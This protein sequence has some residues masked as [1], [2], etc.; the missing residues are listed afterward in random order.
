MKK[1]FL[2]KLGTFAVFVFAGVLLSGCAGRYFSPS[3]CREPDISLEELE[4]KKQLAMDP[5]R[6]FADATSFVQRATLT[7]SLPLLGDT[8]FVIETF[9]KKPDKFRTDMRQD[10]KLIFSTIYNNGQAVRINYT[11]NTVTQVTG[12]ELEELN[13][14]F[15]MNL[16]NSTYQ[17]TFD[18]VEFQECEIDREQYYRVRGI[19][20]HAKIPPMD[21]YIGT[22]SMMTK[23]IVLEGKSEVRIDSYDLYDGVI[24]PDTTSINQDGIELH[25]KVLTYK[26]NANLKESFF[27]LPPVK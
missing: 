10:N 23:G 5:E 20:E 19:T 21:F 26:L 4:G 24:I 25:S 8:V 17:N 27:T 16:P 15:R 1:S 22:T 12:E 3:E 7:Y 6:K 18:K 9:Y 2:C 11:D 13:L 14:V